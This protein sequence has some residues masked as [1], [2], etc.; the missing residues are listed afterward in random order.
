MKKMNDRAA[1]FFARIFYNSVYCSGVDICQS[2]ESAI[3]TVGREIGIKEKRQFILFK[4][5]GD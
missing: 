3:N 4:K 1:L 5:D 2:F